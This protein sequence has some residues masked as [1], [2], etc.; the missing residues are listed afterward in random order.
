MDDGT[1]PQNGFDNTNSQHENELDQASGN[2]ERALLKDWRNQRVEELGEIETQMERLGERR[3]QILSEV[4][5]FDVLL[6]KASV[7]SEEHT[8]GSANR[9][10]SSNVS[11]NTVPEEL[12][13]DQH[14]FYR[15]G[16]RIIRVGMKKDRVT[17]YQTSFTR[18][19]VDAFVKGLSSIGSDGEFKMNSGLLETLRS[20]LSREN[21]YVV[22]TWMVACGIIAE[23]DR[24][25]YQLASHSVVDDV[26]T[27]WERT[28]ALRH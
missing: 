24:N 9:T 22:K 23:I 13:T 17:P 28:P 25:V 27:W 1:P 20:D 21:A 26:Q 10:N 6:G 16:N 14:Q 18:D 4:F 2:N 12:K 8:I 3:R 11:Q 5:A 15:R 19:H 7:V